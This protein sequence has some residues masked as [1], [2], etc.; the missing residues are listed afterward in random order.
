MEQTNTELERAK[1]ENGLPAHLR[2]QE[3]HHRSS[4][5]DRATESPALVWKPQ[6]LELHAYEDPA[7]V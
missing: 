4:G 1:Q 5:R 6:Q 3:H 2:L 7:G